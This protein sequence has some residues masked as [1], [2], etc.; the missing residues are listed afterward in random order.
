[1]NVDWHPIKSE[2]DLPIMPFAK[3][4]QWIT[5]ESPL[6]GRET[7]E[8]WWQGRAVGWRVGRTYYQP[9]EL[10][11]CGVIAWADYTPPAPYEGEA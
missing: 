7:R 5:L 8:A 2:A 1:M 10:G 3:R 11:K 9:W 4:R 6:G